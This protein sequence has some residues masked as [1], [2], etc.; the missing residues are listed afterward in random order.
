MPDKNDPNKSQTTSTSSASSSSSSQ[1]TNSGS[2]TTR[3]TTYPA[4]GFTSYEGSY[5]GNRGKGK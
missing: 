4:N 5:G 1:K 3:E 2:S